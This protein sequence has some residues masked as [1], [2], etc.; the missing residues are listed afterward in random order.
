MDLSFAILGEP[1]HCVQ[2]LEV[3]RA[4]FGCLNLPYIPLENNGENSAVK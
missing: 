4:Y 3:G 2:V 1:F